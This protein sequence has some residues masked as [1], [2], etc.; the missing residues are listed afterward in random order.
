[1]PNYKI[2]VEQINNILPQTQCGDCG[3]SGCAPYASAMLNKNE[4]IDRC[5]PG[6]TETL[7]QLGNLLTQDVDNLLESMA[8]KAKKPMIAFI[9]EAECIGCTKCIQACPVDA[10]IGSAKQL[11]SILNSECTG[12]GLCV[13]PCPVDCIEMHPIEVPLYD[14][15]TA[16]QRYQTRN[17]RL[18][19]EQQKTASIKRTNIAN[20]NNIN[21]KAMK[22]TTIFEAVARIKKKHES[23]KN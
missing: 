21:E 7:I 19:R 12:C 13:A 17:K 9:R 14:I 4:K 6:G 20:T 16:K 22:K 10:I 3:Y 5:L 11:H 23:A 2:T 15:E 18:A 1:M 8:K